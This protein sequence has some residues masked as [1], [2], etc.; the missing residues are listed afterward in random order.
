MAN[1]KDTTIGYRVFSKIVHNE[2]MKQD[3][4]E[5]YGWRA[6]ALAGSVSPRTSR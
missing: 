5:I 2:A 4:Q 3:P 6:I 1:M